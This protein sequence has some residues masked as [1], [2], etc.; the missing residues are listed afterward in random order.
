MGQ[1]RRKGGKSA[2]RKPLSREGGYLITEPH[3]RNIALMYQRHG[4]DVNSRD[5]DSGNELIY[6]ISSMDKS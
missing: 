1:Y 5:A 3:L 6:L 4:N 2:P